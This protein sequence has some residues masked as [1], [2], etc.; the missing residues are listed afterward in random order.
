MSDGLQKACADLG[1]ALDVKALADGKRGRGLKEAEA[2]VQKAV[3]RLRVTVCEY[4]G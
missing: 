4:R 3:G 1:E 2:A